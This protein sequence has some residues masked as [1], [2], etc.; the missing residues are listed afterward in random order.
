MLMSFEK[1][2][3]KSDFFN[4]YKLAEGIYGAIS[5]EN[6][7]M[8]GNC[9]FIDAG[10]FSIV[11]D[12]NTSIQ[13]ASEL[14]NAV[15][16]YT[17]KEPKII[18]TTHY[19]L[20]HVMGNYLY[21]ALTLI[22]TSD[23]TLKSIK[24]ENPKRLEEMT[25]VP[26]EELTKMEDSLKTETNEEKRKEIENNLRFIKSVKSEDFTL[27]DPNVSFKD[28]L[29]IYG[30]ERNIQLKT[31]Q[32]AHTDGDV[33]VYLPNEKI[34]FAGDLLFARSDPWLGSGNPEGWV[35]VIEEIL[36]MDFTIVVPGH[37]QLASKDEFILEKKYIQE[38]VELTRN[39]LKS[40]D[41]PSNI[42]REDF[43]AE[44]Q[45]WESPVL[46]WNINFLKE[47]LK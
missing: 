22:I 8:G 47:F 41:D 4:L 45:A 14:K 36:K 37:G 33:I 2:D 25:N 5:K 6:S 46:E 29:I 31:F 24:T 18:I 39:L 34:L 30:T 21:D 15:K 40:G 1:L 27:R 26:L 20:D 7:G 13:A 9:G 23:R 43:S 3:F 11:I 10:D 44:L 28:E 17:G 32:K 19:H 42:K 12:T 16:Q 38:I 35:P